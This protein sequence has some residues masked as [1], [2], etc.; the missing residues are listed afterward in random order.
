MNK[1]IVIFH[2]KGN[3]DIQTVEVECAWPW[4]AAKMALRELT[5]DQEAEVKKD[6]TSISINATED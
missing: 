1:F 6:C 2:D 4:N 5:A 3:C